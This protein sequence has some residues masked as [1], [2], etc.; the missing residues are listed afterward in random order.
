MD[1]GAVHQLPA[2]A[3]H[4]ALDERGVGLRATWHADHGFLNVSLWTGNR[5][6]QTFH[7]APVEA[8]RLVGFLAQVLGE[9]V[10]EPSRPSALAAVPD[11]PQGADEARRSDRLGAFRREVAGSLERA[12][13][14]LRS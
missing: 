1:A 2:Q 11:T 3:R 9:A 4:F 6:V 14:R 13:R 5:C 7:L 12:A 8:G 10:A